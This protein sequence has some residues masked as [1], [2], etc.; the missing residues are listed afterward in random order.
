MVVSLA[1]LG[2][3]SGFAGEDKKVAASKVPTGSSSFTFT[4]TAEASAAQKLP[5]LDFVGVLPREGIELKAESIY[6]DLDVM[7]QLGAGAL[8][9]GGSGALFGGINQLL[10]TANVAKNK[11]YNLQV[12]QKSTPFEFNFK[13]YLTADN[14]TQARTM[15]SQARGLMKLALPKESET[16]GALIAPGPSPIGSSMSKEIQ[17]TINSGRESASSFLEIKPKTRSPWSLPAEGGRNVTIQV[18]NI[19]TLYDVIV[20]SVAVKF[21]NNFARSSSGDSRFSMP[22]VGEVSISVKCLYQ[23]TQDQLDKMYNVKPDQPN[24]DRTPQVGGNK[25]LGALKTAVKS[26]TGVDLNQP[27]DLYTEK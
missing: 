12:W 7:D 17:S 10:G 13:V 1:N 11:Y 16:L 21:Y 8:S 3:G 25:L 24:T 23:A 14:E 15:Q 20:K 19:L 2:L 5:K 4:L 9:G 27:E 18:G 6:E 26:V 22:V